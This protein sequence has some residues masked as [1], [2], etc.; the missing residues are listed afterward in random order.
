MWCRTSEYKPPGSDKVGLCG[1][2]QPSKV[3]M[4]LDYGL[5]ERQFKN[6]STRFPGVAFVQVGTDCHDHPVAHT[7]Y[8]IVWANIMRKLQPGQKVADISGNPQHNESFLKTQIRRDRPITIDTFCKVQSPRDSVRSKVR[9]G[10]KEVDGRVRWEELTMYDMYRNEAAKTRFAEY[11]VFLMNH[12]LYYYKMEEVTKLLSLNKQSVLFATIHKL[13]GQNGT[14]N[15]GEQSYIKD[16]Q[17]GEVT[18]TNVETGEFYTH[19]D[20]APWFRNFCYADENGAIAWTINKGCD[21]TY[22]ITV[23][24]TEATLV[25]ESCWKDKRIVFAHDNDYLEVTT[26]EVVDTPPAYE[27]EKVLIKSQDI[28][29]GYPSNKVLEIN[30]THPEL[31][32]TLC[33]FMINKPR[34]VRTLGDLTAK[35]H[36]EA[37]NNTLIGNNKRIKIDATALTQHIF[38]AWTRGAALE[39]E[40]FDA[41]HS[42]A[43]AIVNRNLA[44]KHFSMAPTAALKSAVR[45]A[46]GA[47]IILRSKE[48]VE[49]V[50]R[51]VDELL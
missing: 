45:A 40:L 13:D 34:N 30:I 46:L 17:S 19:P 39:A 3:V 24:S 22:V 9:W 41:V 6:L 1:T 4:E 27:V 20:P 51:H 28:V 36:R 37:G 33:A 12:V 25:P 16:L 7:S 32:A 11:D 38:A 2:N 14:I 8:K 23:T 10:P 35:A 49:S 43:Q 42:Q 21:D 5:D 44:G 50:L 18:Q 48:P 31:Y 26:R 29:P 47:T 15:C